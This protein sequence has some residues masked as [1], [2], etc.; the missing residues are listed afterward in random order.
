MTLITICLVLITVALIFGSN[1]AGELLGCMISLIFLGFVIAVLG[2][3]LLV[4]IF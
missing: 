1:A 2:F 3:V 4:L